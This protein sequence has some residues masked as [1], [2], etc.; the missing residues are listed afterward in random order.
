MHDASQE[1]LKKGAM[2][3][4]SARAVQIVDRQFQQQ[5]A[6]GRITNVDVSGID[7]MD[8]VISRLSW[9]TLSMGVMAIAVSNSVEQEPG[10]IDLQPF[11]NRLVYAKGH[12]VRE[13]IIN[14]DRPSEK[15]FEDLVTF[16]RD[17]GVAARTEGVIPHFDP[18]TGEPQIGSVPG[19]EIVRLLERVRSFGGRVKIR[20][21]AKHDLYSADQ[22]SVDFVVGS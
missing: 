5:N 8:A 4:D 3:G 9:Q 11:P 6:D 14:T 17:T 10:A 22:L 7:R 16:L 12:I 2:P 15:I 1:A 19:S 20:A 13:Q 21:V 18:I